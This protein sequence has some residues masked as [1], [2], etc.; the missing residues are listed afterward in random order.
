MSG[1]E[2]VEHP[3]EEIFNPSISM[4]QTQKNSSY[5]EKSSTEEVALFVGQAV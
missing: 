1:K 4:Q 5:A 3:P 2:H